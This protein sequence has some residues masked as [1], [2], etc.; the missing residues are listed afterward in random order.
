MSGTI[1][2]EQHPFKTI[3]HHISHGNP[4]VQFKIKFKIQTWEWGFFVVLFDHSASD[5]LFVGNAFLYP[6]HGGWSC[7]T[8]FLEHQEYHMLL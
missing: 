3:E 2:T 5:P 7:W 4:W 8:Y 6:A 1:S